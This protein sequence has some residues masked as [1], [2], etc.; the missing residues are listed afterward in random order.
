VQPSPKVLVVG[1][2]AD[3]ID[4]IRHSCPGSALFLT[5]RSTRQ[6]AQET[7]PAPFEEILSDLTDHHR[8]LKA[9]QRHLRRERISL[10]GITSYD[11]ES[12][13]LAALLAQDFA[14][15]Y[16][17]P[18]AVRNCRDKFRAKVLWQRHGVPCPRARRI[19]TETDAVD[20]LREIGGPCVLKPIGG[21]GSELVF[22][23]HGGRQCREN[24]VEISRGLEQ[25]RCDRLYA[26]FSSD[27]PLIVAEELVAGEEFSCDFVIENEQVEVL[28]LS[29]K[30]LSKDAPFGTVRAY[31]LLPALPP[32]IESTEF[33][34]TLQQSAKALGVSRAICMMDFLIRDGRPLFLEMAPRPGG[35]CLPFLLRRAR[36]L[37]MIQ[38]NLD[39]ARQHPLRAARSSDRKI[40]V[41]LRV[42]AGNSGILRNMDARRLQQDP[43]VLEVHLNREPGHVIRMPPVDYDSWILGHIIFSPVEGGD[44][45]AQCDELLAAIAVE[46][47]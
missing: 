46:V 25:R 32:A 41:G 17:T 21:S 31:A 12:M 39:F 42:H 44:L 23:C 29:R 11:C 40:Y 35:D 33:H 47:E 20:F 16:P 8:V 2:T 13:A 28:R 6:S 30:I 27:Q 24:F 45:E 10:A 4:W 26:G 5:D 7:P 18:E 34:R 36:N 38:L 14:L 37:D 22:K 19:E 43:R 3:Y 9:L 1:T 15:P